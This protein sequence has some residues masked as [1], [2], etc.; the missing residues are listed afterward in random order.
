MCED[1]FFEGK[2][3]DLLFVEVCVAAGEVSD[4]LDFEEF[5]DSLAFGETTLTDEQIG[6]CAICSSDRFGIG[7]LKVR[8]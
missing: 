3:C 7:R 4:F 5:E 8:S 2:E 6:E 1:F